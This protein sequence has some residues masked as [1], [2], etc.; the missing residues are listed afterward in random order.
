MNHAD[1]VLSNTL[2]T[3][4]LELLHLVA[5]N[6]HNEVDMLRV[7]CVSVGLRDAVERQLFRHPPSSQPSWYFDQFTNECTLQ[8]TKAS[9]LSL[10]PTSTTAPSSSSS[11]SSSSSSSSFSSS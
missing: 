2:S 3:I 7:R 6:L 11:F 1:E 10:S 9:S 5:E 4:P 8:P